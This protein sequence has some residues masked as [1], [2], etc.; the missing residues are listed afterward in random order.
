MPIKVANRAMET[1]TTT[2]TG[3]LTLSGSAVTGYQTF[4]A[5]G[6]NSLTVD[7]TI[8]GI[9]ADQSLTGEYETGRGV[10]TTAGNSLTRVT[11]LE[12]SNA[13][14]LVNFSA[15]TKRVFITVAAEDLPIL[16]NNNVWTVNQTYTLGTITASAPQSKTVT[17]NNAGVT[18]VDEVT[19]LTNTASDAASLFKA[20]QVGGVNVLAIRIDGAIFPYS[21]GT[22]GVGMIPWTNTDTILGTAANNFFRISPFSGG[23]DG[24]PCLIASAIGGFGWASAGGATNSIDT[25]VT[26][27]AAGVV[28]INNGTQGTFRDLKIRNV[29]T[30][31]GNG[32]YVQTP[33]M[34][35]ANL[36]AAATAGAG[37]RAFV[38]DATAT[39][40]LSTVAGGGANKV[41]V[42][43]DG[44]AWLI[45]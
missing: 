25:K 1:S 42:V 20:W 37:A 31:G 38:T 13:D 35:V 7:Y 15:G 19:N 2:G 28:E 30:G 16:Q 9:N 10:Y 34:T 4:T 41:P 32:S 21:S 40:F 11:V 22:I 29:L 24:A 39:T 44:S 45:G 8:E 17:F 36:A 43:S 33:S 6:A 14:A 26:R 12:S 27:S 5:A 18:F 23:G 3:T